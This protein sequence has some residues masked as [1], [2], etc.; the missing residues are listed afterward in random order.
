LTNPSSYAKEMSDRVRIPADLNE[1]D[2]FFS[3]GPLKMSIRQLLLVFGSAMIWYLSARYF[4]GWIGLTLPFAMLATIWIPLIGFA[5]AF[6]KMAG[7]PL[8]VWIA[9]KLAFVFGARTYVMRDPKSGQGIE[10]DLERDQDMD[11]LM[12]YRISDRS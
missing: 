2:V 9:E 12:D 10:A 1:E 8:D 11:A 5:F 6:A 7:R 3:L 4:L